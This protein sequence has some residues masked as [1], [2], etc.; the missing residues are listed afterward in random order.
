M[1]MKI[2]KVMIAAVKSGSGK[3]TITCAFFKTVIMQ[4]KNIRCPLSVT[5]LY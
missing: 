1:G 5:G 3:T 4:E 2:P